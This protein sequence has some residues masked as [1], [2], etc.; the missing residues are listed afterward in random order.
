MA[1]KLNISEKGKAWKI[2]TENEFLIGKSIGD[3]IDGKDIKAEL[4]GYE[5][6]ITGGTD[7]A[8]FSMSKNAEGIGLK[9]VLLKKGWGMHKKR[10][11]LRLRKTVRGKIISPVISQINISVIKAGKKPFTEIFPEQNKLEEKK[12]AEVKSVEATAT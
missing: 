11:G 10:K 4:E 2:E 1:F 9:R 12:Q 6:K 8:G 7:S 5:M 3:T